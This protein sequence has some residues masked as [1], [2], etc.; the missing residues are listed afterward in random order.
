M[1][2]RRAVLLVLILLVAGAACAGR[3][4]TGGPTAGAAPAPA[5]TPAPPPTANTGAA[6]I[7]PTMPPKAAPTALDSVRGLI[8]SL[9]AL[10]AFRNAHWGVLVVDA[11]SGRTLY[12]H[13][14][15]KLFMPASSMKIVT[16]AVALSLL[17]PE[18]RFRT[19]LVATGPL[20]GGTLQGDLIVHGRGDPTVSDSMQASALDPLRGIA[21]SLAARGVR[22]ITGRI[23]PGD[24]VFP[25]SVYG[26]GWSVDDLSETYGAGVDELFFNEGFG[27]L[28]IRGGRVAG[29]PVTVT[30][31]PARG[32]P[33]LRVT[34]TSGAPPIAGGGATRDTA[35]HVTIDSATGRMLVSGRATA[36][37][38]TD[39]DVVFPDQRAA[40]LQALRE[41]LE[42]R[43][44]V[45]GGATLSPRRASYDT[46]VVYRSAP[47]R[48]VIR[49]MEKPS[50]NQIAEILL[51]TI[52]VERTGNGSADSGLAVVTR[53]LLTWGAD[54]DG[55]VL[56]DG[57][58]LSRYN[59][60]S[61]TTLVRTLLAIRRDTAF[62]TF[63]QS[64]P[65]AGVDGTIS[66][67][68]R[69]TPAAGNVHA[70]TGFIANA[71][72]LSGYVTTADGHLLV[73]SALCNNWTAPRPVVEMVQDSI[74][75]RL[76]ALD[77][78]RAH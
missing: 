50:Q 8:D 22:R 39:R 41:A 13:N 5:P 10:P 3:T 57:S 49:R 28:H 78:S 69:N 51:H 21:D 75:S 12:S 40:Y 65:I 58:G 15:D 36:L 29:A 30:T 37:T 6:T 70:K 17:G 55:F 63:Y 71:R 23:L 77:L 34:A 53:M 44:I 56:Q 46:L 47:L 59:Y 26:A 19:T 38:S 33:K 9:I 68:M 27:T 64:L 1:R 14:A 32:Y 66:D 60:L 18:F 74:A 42:S 76:A 73:F 62:E 35:L 61:P 48:D 52:A 7:T 31:T 67:R 72:S 20:T 25:G 54:S 24:D 4:P 45:I 11:D 43:G 16:G 2:N